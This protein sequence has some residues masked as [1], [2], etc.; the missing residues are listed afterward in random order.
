MKKINVMSVIGL[1]LASAGAQAADDQSVEIVAFETINNSHTNNYKEECKQI[2]KDAQARMNSFLSIN[3]DLKPD[4][5]NV[6]T[7]FVYDFSYRGGVMSGGYEY[8]QRT[9]TCLLR[10]RLNDDSRKLKIAKSEVYYTGRGK[11][12][13]CQELKTE[14]DKNPGVIYSEVNNNLIRC[15]VKPI[16]SIEKK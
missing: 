1:L 5:V 4:Q 6:M 16:I 12:L 13:P 9:Y 10:I 11:Y 8:P 3:T 2:E 14:I 7:K 15:N